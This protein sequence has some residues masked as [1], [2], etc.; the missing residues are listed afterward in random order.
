MRTLIQSIRRRR[1]Q[2]GLATALAE[3]PD[4]VVL[5][6]LRELR[7]RESAQVSQQVWEFFSLNADCPGFSVW[8][9]AVKAK[10]SRVQGSQYCC[11][12]VEISE[13]FT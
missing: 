8:S 7:G 2:A 1:E 12:V 10:V 9:V 11:A 6:H 5:D 4:L 13:Q 3:A